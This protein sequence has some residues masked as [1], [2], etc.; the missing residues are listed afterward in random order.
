MVPK[1][2]TIFIK[3]IITYI[4][5]LSILCIMLPKGSESVFCYAHYGKIQNFFFK[6]ISH[7]GE[8]YLLIPLGIYILFKRKELFP[9]VTFIFIFQF[10][11]VHILKRVLDFPRP[12]LFFEKNLSFDLIP[13]VP[14]LLNHSMPSG[15]TALGLCLFYIIS[16]LFP[17]SSIQ[18]VCLILAIGIGLSR[19]FLLCH[20]TEDVLVGTIIGFATCWAGLYYHEY[21]KNTIK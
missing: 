9:T 12:I 8:Y 10:L 3:G 2:N 11:I 16:Y 6:N 7:L 18:L 4:L 17:K 13:G 19:I 21:K 1:G 14:K 20:F 15:H 5:F